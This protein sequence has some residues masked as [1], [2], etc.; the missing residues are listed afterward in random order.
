MKLAISLVA[1]LTAI[2][3][4]FAAGRC[5]RELDY[6]GS[7]LKKMG[8]TDMDLAG[9]AQEG[10]NVNVTDC[11]FYC[12]REDT[13]SFVEACEGSCIEGRSRESDFCCN[14]N[15][16]VCAQCLQHSRQCDWPEQLK[17][18]PE[19]GYI[20]A[21]ELRLRDTEDLLL[22]TLSQISDT[23]LE[24]VLGSDPSNEQSHAGHEQHP[25]RVIRQAKRGNDYWK[26]FPLDTTQNVREWQRDC[27]DHERYRST[28]QEATLEKGRT[29]HPSNTNGIL[30][31][32]NLQNTPKRCD[33]RNDSLVS[34]YSPGESL[35][36]T[37]A[38]LYP[39]VFRR[40]AA[41]QSSGFTAQSNSDL[42]AGLKETHPSSQSASH[43]ARVYEMETPHIEEALGSSLNRPQEANAWSGAPSVNF[44]E[45]FL[46]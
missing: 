23:Q 24:T 41:L 46:W 7:A 35:S 36:P 30:F 10:P 20:E 17:R 2:P 45:Q 39:S 3:T 12:H 18:G 16:P 22:N 8:W 19:K 11:L 27:S 4:V 44:Q 5:S 42:D 9:I 1:L 43:T 6:C 13:L 25:S 38:S 34:E 32:K 33:E 37:H 14:G 21:L 40:S 29:E 26:R 31:A 15:R 28:S